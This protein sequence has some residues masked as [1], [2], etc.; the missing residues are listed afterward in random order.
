MKE[1][2]P[3]T[4]V[5]LIPASPHCIQ[6][7][8]AIHLYSHWKEA[9]WKQDKPFSTGITHAVSK[10]I[11]STKT[12]ILLPTPSI[13][14]KWHFP[15]CLLF[16]Y[17]NHFWKITWSVPVTWWLLIKFLAW[18]HSFGTPRIWR[19]SFH[20]L[21]EKHPPAPP[22]PFR[23]KHSDKILNDSELSSFTTI[24]EEPHVKG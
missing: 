9:K 18:G 15:L 12:G 7:V 22:R 14:L 6:A 8:S 19:A 23:H 24:T 5:Y 2:A 17:Y 20:H 4:E 10:W 11:I 3:L 13:M 1:F 21:Q 16:P